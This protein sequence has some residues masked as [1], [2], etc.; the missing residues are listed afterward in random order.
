M[1][2]DPPSGI[3]A[4]RKSRSVTLTWKAPARPNGIIRG[5]EVKYCKDRCSRIGDVKEFFGTKGTI[6]KLHPNTKYVFQVRCRSS[7][8]LGPNQDISVQ[9]LPDSKFYIY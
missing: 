4:Y 3:S 2:D 1:P 5:Y 6:D 7:G 8:G 9:T